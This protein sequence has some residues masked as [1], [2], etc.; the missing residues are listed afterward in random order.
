MRT[1]TRA[2]ERPSALRRILPSP[3]TRRPMDRWLPPNDALGVT[4]GSTS[5]QRFGQNLV[6]AGDLVK[7]VEVGSHN[8]NRFPIIEGPVVGLR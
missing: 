6:K 3:A 4:W 7:H 8:T 2:P 1:S 5:R